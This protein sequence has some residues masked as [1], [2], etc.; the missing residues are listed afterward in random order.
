MATSSPSRPS[1]YSRDKGML[2]FSTP[3]KAFIE[4]VRPS[5][6]GLS[7]DTSQVSKYMEDD[8]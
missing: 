8:L 6:P 4:L 7:L 5:N 3:P 1:S 2:E